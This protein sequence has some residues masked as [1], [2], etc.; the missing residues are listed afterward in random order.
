[1]IAFD[2]P[3]LYHMHS[4]IPAIVFSTVLKDLNPSIG[5]MTFFM[6]R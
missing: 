4:F 2:L 6:N 1:M 3:F 5:L